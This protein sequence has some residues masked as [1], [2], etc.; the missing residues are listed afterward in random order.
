MR[1]K[2]TQ[3][4]FEQNTYEGRGEGG[5]RG[6]EQVKTGP[7]A[8]WPWNS[9][10]YPRPISQSFWSQRGDRNYCK[11][12]TNCSYSPEISIEIDLKLHF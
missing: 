12:Y 5:V 10:A 2:I 11:K 9:M 8:T 3:S 1:R 4:T 6:M 7:I